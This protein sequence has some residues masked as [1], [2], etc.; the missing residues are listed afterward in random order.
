MSRGKKYRVALDAEGWGAVRAALEFVVRKADVFN[1]ILAQTYRDL[2]R[3]IE[4]QIVRAVLGQPAP[5]ERRVRRS[6]AA[7]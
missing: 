7:D 3:Q 2:D 1:P 4:Q 6:G 5:V